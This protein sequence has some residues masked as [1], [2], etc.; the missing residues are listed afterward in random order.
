MFVLNSIA[1]RVAARQHA[2]ASFFEK[3]LRAPT[4]AE[5]LSLDRSISRRSFAILARHHRQMRIPH[6]IRF[7]LPPLEPG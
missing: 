5:K 7:C 3:M 4:A 1:S 6:V 2:S